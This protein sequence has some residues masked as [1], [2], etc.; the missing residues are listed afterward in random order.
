MKFFVRGALDYDEPGLFLSF[1]EK[2]Q[3]MIK[4]FRSMGFDL[5]SMVPSDQLHISQIEL[6]Q[7]QIV[8]AG[9]FS[10]D[11]LFIQLERGTRAIFCL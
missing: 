11:G 8:E 9:D 5:A 1:E 3:N 7:I 6:D 10:L 2:E 4:N